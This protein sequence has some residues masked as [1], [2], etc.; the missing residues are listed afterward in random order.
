M[1][2]EKIKEGLKRA[3]LKLQQEEKVFFNLPEF[4]VSF[5]SKKE[6]GDYSTNLPFLISKFFKK[7]PIFISQKIKE[8]IL[9]EKESFIFKKIEVKGPG[10]LNFFLSD[11]FLF[12]ELKKFFQNKGRIKFSLRKKKKI[13]IDYFSPNIAKRPS[14]SHL[15]SLIVGHTL[16]KIFNFYGHKALGCN[17]LGDWGTQFGNLICNIKRKKI[18]IKDLT[19]EKMEKIYIDF[20]EKAKKDPSLLEQGRLWFL[21]MEKGDKEA[22][23]IWKYCKDKTRKKIKEILK[24]L[25]IKISLESGESF[26]YKKAKRL[27]LDLLKRRLAKK[28]QGAIIFEFENFPPQILLKSDNTTTYFARDLVSIKE[29]FEKY[30]PDLMIFE[31]GAEQK[32]YFEQLFLGVE[33][34]FGFS[35]EK[36]FH[37]PHGL[38][39]TKEGKLSTREGRVIYLEEIL[40]EAKE[41]AK[42]FLKEGLR[43]KEKKEIS[44]KVGFAGLIF[45]VLKHEPKSDIF[46]D[47]ENILNLKGDTGPYLQYS[48]LRARRIL[49]K[50]R[51]QPKRIKK[52]EKFRIEEKERE[53]IIEILRFP[54]II[55]ECV[56]KISPHFLAVFALNLAKKFNLFYDSLPVLSTKEKRDFRLILT[57]SFH[58][59]LRQIFFLFSLPIPKKM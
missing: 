21:K 55:E 48:L 53:L 51:F 19:L 14:V 32:L 1:I 30:K 56:N 10:F 47:W 59:L 25:N 27:A 37:L 41:R 5:S 40:N 17:Y 20:H 2:K 15:R 24:K 43:E 9:E 54:E 39:K 26:F 16:F 29:R 52:L 12:L 22:L 7:D 34:I 46:F 11:D 33:K 23:K 35:K 49:E 6:F 28:S 57:F 44:Q 31:V 42:K 45:N 50:A 13:F 8:K 4:E 38:L 58:S 18:K 3:V 36:F